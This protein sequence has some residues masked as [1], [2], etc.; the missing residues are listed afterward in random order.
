MKH[1]H[2]IV[3]IVFWLAAAATGWFVLRSELVAQSSSV[4]VM[5]G[6]VSQWLAGRQQ[7]LPTRSDQWLQVALDDPIFLES[8]DGTYRQVGLVVNIDGKYVRDPRPTKKFEVVIYDDALDAFPDGF[9]L[10][11]HTTPMSLDWVVRTMIPR[12]R[13]KEIAAFIAAEWRRHQQEV[14]AELRPVVRDGVRTALQAVEAELPEILKNH[15]EDFQALGD[16]YETEILKAELLP[17]VREEILPIV[18]EEA[19]PVAEEVGRTLWN[20][21]SL[22][23]FAWRA[24]YDR[25]PLPR[26]DA[27]K[28]EFQRFVDEE[29]LP[30]LRSRSDQFIEVTETIVKRSMENPRVKEILKRS[31]KRVAEDPELH[32]LV[33]SVVREAVVENQTLRMELESYMQEQQTRAAMKLAGERMEPMVREIGDMIFGTREKGITP[34]F[35]RILRSQILKKDRR[36]FVMRPDGMTKDGIT[37]H[38]TTD[39]NAVTGPSF[40]QVRAIMASEPM[41]YPLGFGGHDQSPLTPVVE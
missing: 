12:D 20:R 7:A 9:Q 23:S 38:R 36:W 14:M 11:Y 25:S 21:V 5:T 19:L 3:G 8:D 15:R 10:E 32:R 30:E 39:G 41:T 28:V 24:L 18:E 17:L 40:G 4:S 22:W 33:W 2:L 37:K 34:E 29:A 6:S 31:L 13:Q 1:R 27:V 16:R 35:S 26:R